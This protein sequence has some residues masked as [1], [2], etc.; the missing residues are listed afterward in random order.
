MSAVLTN[1]YNHYLTTYAPKGTTQYDTHKKSELR[2]VYNSIVKMNKDTPWYLPVNKGETLAYA[3]GI[4]EHARELRN[5]IASLGGLN[6]DELL[7]KKIAYCD[8]EEIATA[9]F[10]G[11]YNEGDSIPELELEVKNL[12]TTQEN[13]GRYLADEKVALPPDTY[14]FDVNINGLSYEFQFNIKEEETNLSVQKRLMKLINNNNIGIKADLHETESGTALRLTSVNTGCDKENGLL[15]TVSDANT[16]KAAGTVE[17]LGLNYTSRKAA[18]ASFVLNGEERSASSNNFTVGKLYE[19]ALKGVCGKDQPVKIGLKTDLE[20][21]TENAHRLVGGYNAFLQAVDKYIGTFP[22]SSSLTNEMGSIA[23][24]YKNELNSWGLNLQQDNRITID[25]K[26]MSQTVTEENVP[27]F[28]ST[29]KNFATS[30]IQKTAQVSLDPMKYVDKTVV[31]YKNPEHT[32]TNPY[33]PSPYSGM[34]FNSY[35]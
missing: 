5:T 9:S 7:N 21:V 32:F 20:S 18:N 8:N 10:I 19:V 23:Y 6:K 2:G 4:K 24:L 1:V 17:Y 30:L 27:E 3:V 33:A 16:G 13:L 22:K 28:L 15:F 31:A 25:E 35:C 29:I 14:S 26:L 11:E 12:A 34:L